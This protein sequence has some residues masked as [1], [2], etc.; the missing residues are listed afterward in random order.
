MLEAWGQGQH[1]AHWPCLWNLFQINLKTPLPVL[2][3]EYFFM[4]HCLQYW[5]KI[6]WIEWILFLK[7][8]V[9]KLLIHFVCAWLCMRAK[10][11]GHA[12]ERET[13]R[14]RANRWLTL[15]C[16]FTSQMCGSQGLNR[17]FQLAVRIPLISQGVSFS[18]QPKSSAR[19]GTQ[20]LAFGNKMQAFQVRFWQ[21]F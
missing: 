15:N 21:L 8:Y 17:V 19:N 4:E 6:D 12:P 1:T 13:E 5:V 7:F 2:V 9:K 14:E 10:A 18:R 3:T 20:I 11:R 16:W